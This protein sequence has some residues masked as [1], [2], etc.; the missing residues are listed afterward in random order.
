MTVVMFILYMGAVIPFL[1]W[2][3]A[4]DRASTTYTRTSS[5]RSSVHCNKLAAADTASLRGRQSCSHSRG[6]RLRLHCREPLHSETTVRT[7]ARNIYTNWESRPKKSCLALSTIRN[8]AKSIRCFP[9]S[10]LSQQF[11]EAKKLFF[12]HLVDC[13]LRL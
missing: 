4:E 1:A 5:K 6:P 7:H 8:L 10:Q 3:G 2:G 9:S 11:V 13:I 12:T